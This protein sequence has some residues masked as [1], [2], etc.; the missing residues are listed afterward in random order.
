MSLSRASGARRRRPVDSGNRSSGVGHGLVGPGSAIVLDVIRVR[1]FAD[2]S[3]ICQPEDPGV[4]ASRGWTFG[5][6]DLQCSS[7]LEVE[8]VD[9]S[10]LGSGVSMLAALSKAKT[11]IPGLDDVTGGGLPRDARR[12]CAAVRGAG[13]R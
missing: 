8:M 12:C 13:R 1:V 9:G 10:E 6:G 3:A 5:Q 4:S 2:V 7:R 11:G